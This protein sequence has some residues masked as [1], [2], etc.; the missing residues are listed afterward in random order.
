[1]TS[2]S[3]ILKNMEKKETLEE[4]SSR[5]GALNLIAKSKSTMDNPP[6]DPAPAASSGDSMW[7]A[8]R[9]V[10]GN[11]IGLH[12][13]SQPSP[14]KTTNNPDDSGT[15]T[16]NPPPSTNIPTPPPKRPDNFSTN[17]SSPSNFKDAFS[18]ARQA[19]AAKGNASGGQ[20]S[21]GGKSYQTNVAGEKYTPASSQTKVSYTPASSNPPPSTNIPTP[22]QKP[23]DLG[24]SSS[25][26]SSPSFTAPS[27]SYTLPS[28]VTGSPVASPNISTS[29][30][31]SD[32]TQPPVAKMTNTKTASNSSDDTNE[33][34][35]IKAVLALETRQNPNMFAAVKKSTLN[36]AR[37]VGTHQSN[38]SDRSA[39]VYHDGEWNEYVVRHYSG[40]THHKEADYHTNDAEDAHGT[41][42]HWCKSLKEEYTAK[43]VEG[44]E[45]DKKEDKKNAKKHGESVKDWEGSAADKKA[46]AKLAKKL[47]KDKVE[48]EIEFSQAEIDF[49]NSIME[50]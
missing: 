20:F 18:Q 9:K 43:S 31:P 50:E 17:S 7:T 30:S 39:K 21:Y 46:D 11:A 35:L 1:M 45:E 5:A 19:A 25:T 38:I 15:S 6:T 42:K 4:G 37:L 40:K 36:E 26:T 48:E 27:Q 34:V 29:S 12:N 33:D 8:L 24:T 23:T 16:S 14:V 22:P 13:P 3:D 32:T 10:A 49:I 47:N 41:A 2:I 44:T 28:K